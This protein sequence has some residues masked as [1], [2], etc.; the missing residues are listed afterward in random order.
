MVNTID[1]ANN[2]LITG[3]DDTLVQLH[4]TQQM[5]REALHLGQSV[6]PLIYKNSTQAER[7]QLA[8]TDK[9]TF[10]LLKSWA[11]RLA[12][13]LAHMHF[14][15]TYATRY[16]MS[17]VVIANVLTK[18]EADPQMLKPDWALHIECNQNCSL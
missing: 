9:P 18:T 15:L 3:M 8:N 14:S 2:C 6:L 5:L 11:I 12:V 7:R 17:K 4:I 16:T 1:E 10:D 13:Q